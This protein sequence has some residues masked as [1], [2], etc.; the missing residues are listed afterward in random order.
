MSME[1]ILQ[2]KE[3]L[4]SKLYNRALSSNS[5]EI[6]DTKSQNRGK[7]IEMIFWAYTIIGSPGNQYHILAQ[8]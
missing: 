1:E 4:G 3:K 7:G 6:K 5:A 2:L 8:D